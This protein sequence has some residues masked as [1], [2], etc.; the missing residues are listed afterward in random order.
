M[1]ETIKIPNLVNTIKVQ[2][3]SSSGTIDLTCNLVKIDAVSSITAALPSGT[4]EGQIVRIKKTD[5]NLLPMTITDG[6]LSTTLDTIGEEVQL[7]WTGGA[8]EVD[9]RI[10]PE[11]DISSLTSIVY[12]GSPTVTDTTHV[13]T[14]RGK[15]AYVKGGATITTVNSNLAGFTFSNLTILANNTGFADRMPIGYFHN[16]VPGGAVISN[17]SLFQPQSS[18]VIRF[19]NNGQNIVRAYFLIRTWANLFS[20]GNG[21][22]FEFQVTIDGWNG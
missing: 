11:V 9:Q 5:N 21:I 8:W 12:D 4:I 17:R 15:Y 10:V 13:V 1:S 20:N 3:L 14:R 7:L 6:V 22:G 18:T 2:T 19:A 16:F